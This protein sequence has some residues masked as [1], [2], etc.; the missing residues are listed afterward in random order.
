MDWIAQGIRVMA[1]KPEVLPAGGSPAIGGVIV[2]IAK[3]VKPLAHSSAQ[4]FAT[5]GGAII[6]RLIQQCRHI[7]V[8]KGLGVL[9]GKQLAELVHLRQFGD[10]IWLGV[11]GIVGGIVHLGHGQISAAGA[12]VI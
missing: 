5:N 9:L 2:E 4:E 11:G 12:A 8:R 6:F 3:L 10:D 1:I 7:V